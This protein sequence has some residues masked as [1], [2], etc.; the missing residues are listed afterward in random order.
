LMGVQILRTQLGAPDASGRRAPV[1]IPGSEFLL[2]V[3]LV[4][5]AIGQLPPAKLDQLLP[6]VE[7]N[8]WGY[9]ITG[10]G[11]TRTSLPNVYAGGDIVNGGS[12]AVA[13]ITAGMLAAEEMGG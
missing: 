8:K 5:E 3:D 2:E 6:G 1:V 9:I 4:V 10:E 13:A 7:L 12:T 11:T